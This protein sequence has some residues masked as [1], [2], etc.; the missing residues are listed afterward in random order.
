MKQK[1]K[2]PLVYLWA[3]VPVASAALF[4]LMLMI[5]TEICHAAVGRFVVVFPALLRSA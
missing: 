4:Y 1:A 3:L 2:N 5:D